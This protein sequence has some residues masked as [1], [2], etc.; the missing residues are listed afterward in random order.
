[1]PGLA[2]ER[3]APGER[4]GG[5]WFA[6]D[7]S[8]APD[9]YPIDPLGAFMVQLVK[10]ASPIKY[11]DVSGFIQSLQ[12]CN[13]RVWK[14]TTMQYQAAADQSDDEDRRTQ[15]QAQTHFLRC[16]EY[17]YFVQVRHNVLIKLSLQIALDM[18]AD[19]TP[20]Q[21]RRSQ[22]ILGEALS[23]LTRHIVEASP[24]VDA[25]CHV[26]KTLAVRE[27]CAIPA[28]KFEQTGFR[29]SLSPRQLTAAAVPHIM[30]E[31][32]S[33]CRDSGAGHH[34]ARRIRTGHGQSQSSPGQE[35]MATSISCDVVELP[36]TANTRHACTLHSP[37]A[38]VTSPP[39]TL[40]P[41][42]WRMVTE[43]Q[44][45]P[46]VNIPSHHFSAHKASSTSASAPFLDT[47]A[48]LRE[49]VGCAARDQLAKPE[50][51]RGQ[52]PKSSP[53]TVP[54]SSS[55]GGGAGHSDDDDD[56]EYLAMVHTY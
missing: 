23:I 46:G 35:H 18:L 29:F 34:M 9:Q 40:S 22:E 19:L 13:R 21:R 16:T 53:K 31:S 47:T 39:A 52:R 44:P 14:L 7:R 1:M 33:G 36:L 54:E 42:T 8:H 2:G 26:E 24:H 4:E 37:Q 41:P 6:L 27:S 11:G 3:G 56:D 55:D 49:G 43:A 12:K 15:V 25:S 51:V 17:F 28:E 38:P 45:T 50:C 10:T 30:Y 32:E 20:A 48:S 5:S